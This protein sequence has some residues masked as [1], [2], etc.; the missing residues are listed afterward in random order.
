MMT[1]ESPER[2]LEINN[3]NMLEDV[4]LKYCLKDEV[5]QIESDPKAN[6]ICNPTMYKQDENTKSSETHSIHR[7]GALTIKNLIVLL[8]NIG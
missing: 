6:E 4:V 7:I 2:L 5:P 1:E 3:A 8:R